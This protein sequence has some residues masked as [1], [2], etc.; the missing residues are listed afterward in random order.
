MALTFNSK[1]IKK[2]VSIDDLEK[3]SNPELDLLEQELETAIKTMNESIASITHEKY[4]QGEEVNADWLVKIKRKEQICNTFLEKIQTNIALNKSEFV[5]QK[6]QQ[7]LNKLL[8]EILG[9]EQYED[10]KS[11]AKNLA[12]DEVVKHE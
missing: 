10:L 9:K 5:R 2:V 11:K 3:L 1:T 4:S 8:Q 12:F 7:N 6:Y